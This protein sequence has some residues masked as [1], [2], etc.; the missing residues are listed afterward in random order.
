MIKNRIAQL[1]QLLNKE[2]IQAYI[3]PSTDTHQSEYLPELWRR[4]AWISGFTGSAGDVVVT[5]E[6]AALWTDSRYFLQAEEQLRN[7]GIQLVKMGV[8]NEPD[9]PAFLK[10]HLQKGDRVGIDP[11]VISH[12]DAGRMTNL[13]KKHGLELTFIENNL[14]D[15]IWDN[16]PPLP[17]YP[18]KLWPEKYAGEKASVKIARLREQMAREYADV[19]VISAL[20]QIAWLFNIR[21]RDV[22]YNPVVVAYGIITMEE[23]L[24]FVDK[25]KLST[26]DR[27]VLSAEMSIRTYEEFQM[28][29]KSLRKNG[30]RF[31]LDPALTSQ[32]IYN[33]VNGK[34]T[35]ILQSNPITAMKALKNE[36]E[37]AGFRNCHIRDG[38]AMVKFL[39]WLTGAVPAGNVDEISASDKLLSFREEQEYFQGESFSPISAYAAHGAIVHYSATRESAAQLK[40]EGIY[41]IDSGG[42]YIDGTTDITR[43][44]ALGTPTDE[45]KDRFTR[46][47][48]GNIALATARFPVGTTGIQLDTLAR[49]ALWD[50]AENYGHGTGHGLGVY[51]NVHEGPQ[52]ISYYRGIGVALEPGMISSNEPGYY[53]EGE[54]GIRIENLIE[55]IKDPNTSPSGTQFLKF[56]VATLCPIDLNLIEKSILT[57]DEINYINDY[58]KRVFDTL[59]DN[60]N[61][62]EREWLKEATGAL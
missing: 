8:P 31:W 22:E 49:K 46:V 44:V 13:L 30:S 60:L 48:K 39:H 38:V 36:T 14:V 52:A 58:H 41:L 43:T 26:E 55:V 25:K 3:I 35:L 29:L 21:G 7:T 42:Q 18:L 10:E 9:I 56:A 40:P 2:D 45:Q 19:L 24:L 51:L 23:A 32:W 61:D 20:D 16:Q 53:K 54:Y 33:L 34:D 62:S 57:E 12:A 1:Q 4:R 15:L 37:L 28:H 6:K 17:Q 59:K 11:R 5:A 47:L 27:D 50:I